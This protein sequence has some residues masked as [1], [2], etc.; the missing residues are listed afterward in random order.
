MFAVLAGLF[1]KGFAILD[2]YNMNGT[3]ATYG[4][5]LAYVLIAVGAVVSASRDKTLSAWL[6]FSAVVGT[7]FM[8]LAVKGSISPWPAAPD[9]YL[10]EIFG[11]YMV[12]GLIWMFVDRQRSGPK[13]RLSSGN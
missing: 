4:F 10:P 1:L 8:G 11:V 3:I 13:F 12:L 5:L 9:N 2:I 7:V 6:I